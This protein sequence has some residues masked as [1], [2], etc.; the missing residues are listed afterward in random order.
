[1]HMLLYLIPADWG[2]KA[3]WKSLKW[4]W[5]GGGMGEAFS[6]KLPCSSTGALLTQFISCSG[7]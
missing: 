3:E 6:C 4:E 1:M 7:D 5:G 2:K